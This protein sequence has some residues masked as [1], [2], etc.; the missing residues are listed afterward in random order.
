MIGRTK[1][2]ATNRE[3]HLAIARADSAA[4]E[5]WRQVIPLFSLIDRP[6]IPDQNERM[7]VL[8]DFQQIC[9]NV[10]APELKALA[11]RLDNLEKRLDTFERSVD[12]R[13]T[14][15]DKLA[16]ARHNEVMANFEAMK[17]N[18][19]LNSRIERLEAQQSAPQ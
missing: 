9:Q 13:L 4:Q 12:T 15:Q 5:G 11:V 1:S 8:A 3:P 17:I 18:L 7:S 19:Q 16:E 14:N 2:R 6:S 10:L